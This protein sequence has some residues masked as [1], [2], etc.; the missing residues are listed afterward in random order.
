MLCMKKIPGLSTAIIE[1]VVEIFPP[2]PYSLYIGIHLW[3]ERN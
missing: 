3:D 2:R 1:D